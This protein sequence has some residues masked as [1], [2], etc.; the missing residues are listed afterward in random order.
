MTHPESPEE[1]LRWAPPDT[2]PSAPPTRE[3]LESRIAHR[4]FRRRAWSAGCIGFLVLLAGLSGNKSI[5]LPSPQLADF[6]DRIESSGVP[7]HAPNTDRVRS[8]ANASVGDGADPVT[9]FDVTATVVHYAPVLQPIAPD[10]N[11]LNAYELIGWQEVID[12]VE[13]DTRS[14][15]ISARQRFESTLRDD[16]AGTDDF[17]LPDTSLVF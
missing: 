2:P 15:P 13:V 8:H 5:D 1:R 10:S 7:Q 11:G 17:A 16:Q 3:G 6:T 9:E 12:T 4:R 14:L